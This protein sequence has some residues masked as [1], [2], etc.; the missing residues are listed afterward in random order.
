MPVIFIH[1]VNTRESEQYHKNVA[2]RD[3]LLRRYLVQ[4]LAVKGARFEKLAIA[5]AYWG[6]HGVRFRWNQATLPEVSTLEHLGGGDESTPQSDLDFALMIAARPTSDGGASGLEAL[7][8]AESPLQRAAAADPERFMEAVLSPLILA[9]RDLTLDVGEPPETVGKREA[10][11]LAAGAEAANDPAT[12]AQV[13]AAGSDDEVM[14]LLKAAVL[15]RYEAILLQSDLVTPEE[16][17]LA[18]SNL[19]GLGPGWLEGLKSRAGEFFDRAADAPKRAASLPALQKVRDGLHRELTQFFGDV[20]VYLNE[21]GEQST[22]G[23][24]V[25][26]VLET[27]QNAPRH[28]PNE[29]LIVMTHSMGGNIFYDILTTYAPDMQVDA[30]ISVGGQVGQFEEMKLFRGSDP[31]LGA[32]NK[33]ASLKPRVGAWLNV[34]DPA[35][36]FSFKAAPVFEDVTDQPFLTGSSAFKSHSDYFLRPSFYTMVRE[37]IAG[38]LQ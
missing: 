33:V 20:F 7:G 2:A 22:P 23:P 9:E 18:E 19:E 38:A 16:A 14:A 17:A 30:W 3:E 37:R 1:G 27:I 25:K 26:T 36:P 12:Q 10:L 8:G 24:I 13:A 21:R 5:N 35:D 28:H 6:K 29:P 34:Y 4:P 11:L 32:P 31:T 15:Q